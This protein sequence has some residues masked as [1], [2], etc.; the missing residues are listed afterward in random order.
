VYLLAGTPCAALSPRTGDFAMTAAV[1]TNRATAAHDDFHTRTVGSLGVDFHWS[2]RNS[3]RGT[4]GTLDLPSRGSDEQGD[5]SSLYLTANVSHNWFGG[6]LFPY[7]TGGAGLYKVEE[8]TGGPDD[9][10]HLEVGLNGGVGLEARLSDTL[11]V[12]LEAG[13]HALTGD[14]PSTI[15]VGSVGIKFYF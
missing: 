9:E 15:A 11:T 6:K 1:G 2:S 14:T 13:V 7:V 3:L 5:V 12:R 10:D 4:L 8:E